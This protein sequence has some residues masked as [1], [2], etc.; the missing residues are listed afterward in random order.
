MSSHVHRVVVPAKHVDERDA[1]LTPLSFENHQARGATRFSRRATSVSYH[2]LPTL[3]EE[4]FPRLGK[5]CG[6]EDAA[7]ARS[8]HPVDP[9]IRVLVVVSLELFAHAILHRFAESCKYERWHTPGQTNVD[10]YFRHLKQ[11]K[12]VT[13]SLHDLYIRDLVP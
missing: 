2:L 3:I 8:D 12:H 10:K 9:T 6:V 1:H 7:L 11:S 5:P 13:V 4:L